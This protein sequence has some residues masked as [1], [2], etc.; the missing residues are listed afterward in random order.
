MRMKYSSYR[1]SYVSLRKMTVIRIVEEMFS[2]HEKNRLHQWRL[3]RESITSV[4]CYNTM[5]KRIIHRGSAKMIF[6][7]KL[8]ELSF[9]VRC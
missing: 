6:Q 9:F 3:R 7:F 4:D 5:P 1:N 8:N 2:L